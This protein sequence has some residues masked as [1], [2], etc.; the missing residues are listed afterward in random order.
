MEVKNIEILYDLEKID[1]ENID[2]DVFVT[3]EDG[4][5]YN[6]SFATPKFFA[7]V[8]DEEK[9]NY[10]GPGYPNIIVKKITKEIINEAVEAYVKHGDGY[11]VNLYHFGG[12]IRAIDQK[13]FDQLKAE[14]IKNQKQTEELIKLDELMEELKKLRNA[15]TLKEVDQVNGSS[16][17]INF[18]RLE[19]SVNELIKLK[20]E[21]KYESDNS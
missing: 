21:E 6:L 20:E 2:I 4:F 13:I 14:S 8:M 19:E 18:N 3:I 1:I 9:S 7:S 16:L 15:L 11:W 17:L 10:Y 5:S 12:Q